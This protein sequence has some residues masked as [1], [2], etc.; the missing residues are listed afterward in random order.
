MDLLVVRAR[1]AATAGVAGRS[2]SVEV[3]CTTKSAWNSGGGAGSRRGWTASTTCSTGTSWCSCSFS[4]PAWR[5]WTR[6]M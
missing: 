1:G 2:D 4:V 6:W 5:A 3:F